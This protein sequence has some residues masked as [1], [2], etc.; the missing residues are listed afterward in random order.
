MTTQALALIVEDN[1]DLATIF[2]TAMASAGCTTEVIKDGSE[3]SERLRGDPVPD[4]VI[5]DLHLPG[6]SGRELAYQIRA[7]ERLAGTKVLVATAEAHM[8]TELEEEDLA[9]LILQKPVL[10]MQLQTLAQ[11][12]LSQR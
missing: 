7:D 6:L 3:A 9:D 5:L 12:L 11:R 8:A 10:F 2:A 4:I 1:P